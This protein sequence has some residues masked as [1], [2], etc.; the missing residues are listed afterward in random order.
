MPAEKIKELVDSHL[1]RFKLNMEQNIVC[2]TTD[3]ASVMV[4]FGR[5]VLPELQLCYAHAVHLAVT[6]VLYRRVHREELADVPERVMETES[7]E[8]E[9]SGPESDE[10]SAECVDGAYR[11]VWPGLRKD[12]KTWASTCV[13]CQRAKVQR[14]VTAPLGP[15]SIPERRFE[16]VHVDLVGP[17][18][19]S[20][21][22]THLLT[23]VDRATRWPE[24]VPLSSATPADVARAFI[25]SWVSRFGVPL[26]LKSDMGPQFTSELWTSVAGSL[27]V[28]LHQPTACHRQTNGLC[29]RFHRT[30]KGALRASLVD[31]SWVDW[32]PWVL[33]G[34]RFAP[35]EDL[36]SSSAELVLA[37]TLRVPG[38]F[39]HTAPGLVPP[40]PAFFSSGSFQTGCGAPLYPSLSPMSLGTLYGPGSSSSGGS[41]RSLRPRERLGEGPGRDSAEALGET[42][43]R[44]RESRWRQTPPQRLKG[45][46]VLC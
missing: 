18:P 37:Q 34:L 42:R 46:G 44:P 22:F 9:D 15:F 13:A 41:G 26:D 35:K 31:N 5:L 14:H 43:R 4:K 38:E 32:L 17:L 40:F 25:Y 19:P 33:L 8:E 12:V 7:E 10:D 36:R 2:C 21:G 3:G 23:M 39:L 16:H 1:H 30:M 24:V 45:A 29:E 6:D 11:F 28:K 27:G 20:R